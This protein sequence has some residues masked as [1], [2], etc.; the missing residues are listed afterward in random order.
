M[1]RIT[2]LATRVS[3]NLEAPCGETLSE[4]APEK[5]YATTFATLTRARSLVVN[6]QQLEADGWRRNLL[7]PGGAAGMTTQFVVGATRDTDR[8]IVQRVSEL[9]RAAA[10][11]TSTSAPFA[12]FVT[13]RS[14]PATPSRAA[15]TPAVS[16]RLSPPLLRVQR[17]R[18]RLSGGW[19]PAARPRSKGRVG[20]R[21]SGAL[22]CRRCDRLVSNAC[23]RSWHRRRRG[24]PHRRAPREYDHSRSLG[25]SK[26]RCPND[27]RDG[28]HRA[29]GSGA[30]RGTLVRAARILAR[31][32]RS[33]ALQAGL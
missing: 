24:A 5:S 27:A 29:Q 3:I 1:E 11:T 19:Q 13:R 9:T 22:S 6:E 18:R 21:A 32:G 16:S 12:R 23:S 28:I 8:T 4:I 30:R 10:F 17:R 7:R 2:D 20:A 14:K 15:R 26:A 31:G 25:P 33:R